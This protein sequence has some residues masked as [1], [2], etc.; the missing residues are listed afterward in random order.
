MSFLYVG[1]EVRAGYIA[2]GEDLI[3]FVYSLCGLYKILI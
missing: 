1:I 2:L 3:V